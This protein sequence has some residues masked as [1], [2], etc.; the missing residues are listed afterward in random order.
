MGL[1]ESRPLRL[2]LLIPESMDGFSIP[3][4]I[5]TP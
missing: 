5:S 4:S 2:Q 1:L 3:V